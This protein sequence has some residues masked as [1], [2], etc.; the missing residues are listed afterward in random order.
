ML[1][2][3][4]PRWD[5]SRPTLAERST[6]GAGPEERAA[7]PAR[8]RPVS[9]RHCWVSDLPALPGRHA[10]LLVEWRRGPDE[11]WQARVVYAVVEDDSP[12]LV[13][14]WVPAAHLTPAR[15]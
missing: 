3:M 14:A 7:D 8:P 1:E 11:Q 6:G 9:T 10:A 13:E 15:R 4:A 12:V 5:A 2:G